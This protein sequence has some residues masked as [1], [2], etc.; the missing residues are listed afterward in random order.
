MSYRVIF[1][2]TICFTLQLRSQVLKRLLFADLASMRYV[3]PGV[4]QHCLI[5]VIRF[6]IFIQ[7]LPYGFGFGDSV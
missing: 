4:P 7:N 5:P 6:P 2:L 3:H 1:E